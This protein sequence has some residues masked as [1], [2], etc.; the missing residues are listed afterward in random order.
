[1]EGLRRGNPEGTNN[2][3]MKRIALIG[4][5]QLGSRH[6]QA[7]AKLDIPVVLEVVDPNNRSLE[8]ARAR[9]LQI[10][11]NS[12]VRGIRFLSA[13]DELESDLDLCI[14]ATNADVRFKVLQE[15]LFKKHVSCVIL[16]K[17]AFQ[18]HQQF[19]EARNLLLQK[20]VSCWVNCPRRLFPIY[21]DMRKRLADDEEIECRVS[22]GDWG[23]ACNGIHFI[24]LLAFLAGDSSY[25]LDGSRLDR[26]IWPSKRPGFIEVTGELTGTFSGGSRIEL[27]SIAGSNE[28]LIIS[29]T[30]SQ[31]KVVID[32]NRGSAIMATSK[33][34]WKEDS[35]TFKVPF[36]SEITHQVAKEILELGTCKLTS[37]DESYQL[38]SPFLETLKRHLET[39]E[40]RRWACCPIT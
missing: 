36:Q 35:H 37:F 1:M 33:N 27:K 9:Y 6:L 25:Q 17:I 18:S 4:T 10:P 31:L 38:H 21:E 30:T 3:A 19:E 24:D 5:G 39:V 26:R 22:G 29:M 16:E 40:Q 28:P 2:N 32:E 20:D 34:N 8:I 12:N 7:L 13:L 15:L 11:E 23:L 14:I